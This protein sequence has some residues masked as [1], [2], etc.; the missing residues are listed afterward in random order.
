MLRRRTRLEALVEELDRLPPA[1][2]ARRIAQVSDR[3]ADAEQDEDDLDETARDAL[4]DET[5]AA[6][7]LDRLRAEV[8]ALGDLAAH[9]GRVREDGRDSKLVS[10]S[11]RAW[12]GRNSTR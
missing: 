5:T 2:R 9:V 3:I 1:R 4:V 6:Y 12:S 8:A 7:E 11:A 10:R